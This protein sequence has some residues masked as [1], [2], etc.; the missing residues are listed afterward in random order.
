MDLLNSLWD[1]QQP[2]RSLYVLCVEPVC[3]TY[4]VTRA[5]LEIL[6][7][8]EEHPR[9]DTAAEIVGRR[10]LAK[11]HVSTSIRSLERGGYLTRS[12]GQ[13]DRRRVH[14]RL[15]PQAGPLLRAGREAQDR[16]LG[17]ITAGLSRADRARLRGY[18]AKI[19]GNIQAS[20]EDRGKAAAPPFG[21]T[22]A[23]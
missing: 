18:I 13:S 5:E 7:F 15:T 12:A 16:F 1:L 23:G 11:S 6:L 19:E 22:G 14:L 21:P 20:L 2:L 17:L 9:R 3:R 4:G 8:L 10:Y